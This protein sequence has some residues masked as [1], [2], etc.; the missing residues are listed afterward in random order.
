MARKAS[1]KASASMTDCV[2]TVNKVLKNRLSLNTATEIIYIIQRLPWESEIQ[3][4]DYDEERFYPDDDI[5]YHRKW[6]DTD[7]TD[8][9][10][11]LE[12]DH[13]V[14]FK[15]KDLEAAIK[16]V[17][18][19]NKANPLRE[20][21]LSLMWDSVPRLNT[22]LQDY[23][24]AEGASKELVSQ[25][26]RKF[27]IGMV[28]RAL[29]PGS[30]FDYMLILQGPQGI[31]K[32]TV[33]SILAGPEEFYCEDFT[34]LESK[35]VVEKC[36]GKM[37]VE[38]GELALFAGK[39]DQRQLKQFISRSTDSCRLS[40]R[41]NGEDIPRTFSFIGTTN[42]FNYLQ[43]ETGNRRYWPIIC[44]K[45]IDLQELKKVRDYLLA[46]AVIVVEHE[47]EKPL[48]DP[49]YHKELTTLQESKIQVNELLIR[50][51]RFDWEI[52][53]ASRNDKDK[54][55]SSSYVLG[56]ARENCEGKFSNE[57]FGRALVRLGCSRLHSRN[58]NRWFMPDVPIA[59]EDEE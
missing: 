38:I 47:H 58:G 31:G 1:V 42:S 20:H 15:D 51:F 29:Y 49:K 23:L 2:M 7:E 34:E 53:L 54:T 10:M 17:A 45:P 24:F 19:E 46:E 35:V 50:F 13:R 33:C 41:R 43:D 27:L 8:L 4:D 32:S 30:K 59:G 36:S 55:I 22:W 21:L 37:I 39:R 11:Y 18:S 26:G 48:I 9:K 56:Y 3:M 44:P 6:R 5:R 40:Y 25:I 52:L 28:K 57:D 12:R 16:R 14:R